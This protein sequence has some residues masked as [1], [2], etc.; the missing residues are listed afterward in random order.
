A[1]CAKKMF[2]IDQDGDG[3]GDPNNVV[4]AC[5]KPPGTVTVGD[6]CNDHDL[7][8]FPGARELCDGR[9]NDCNAATVEVCPTGRTAVRRPAPDDA[10]VYLF[11]TNATSWTNARTFCTTNG[12][13]LVEIDS[14]AENQ[15]VLAE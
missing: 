9:D 4:M 15:F 2:F 3:H 13:H 12:Y 10:H 1:A 11:C 5:E 7:N 6:D 8:T 14:D